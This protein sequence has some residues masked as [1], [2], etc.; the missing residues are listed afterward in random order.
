MILVI[1]ATG[2]IG[3]DVVK[4]LNANGEQVRAMVRDLEKAKAAQEPGVE[5]VTGELEKPETVMAALQSS[6]KAFL[7]SPESEQMPELHG[8][9]AAAAKDAGVRHLVRL[10]IL[11]ANPDAPIPLA[12]WH[13][14]ADRAVMD[15]GVPYTVLRPSYFMQNS[16]GG[17]ATVASDGAI[18]SAMGD[19]KAGQIDTRDIA[20]VAVAVLTSEGHGGQSY[21]LTGPEALSMTEVA[22]RLSSALGKTIEYVNL[23]PDKLTARMVA[24]GVPDWRAEVWVKLAGMIGLGIASMVTPAVKEVLGR[25]PAS[26]DQFAKDFAAEFEKGGVALARKV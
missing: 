20:D 16:L 24:T 14:E 15:S 8:K 1:G 13:G 11:P 19:G 23:T 18:Y 12:K 5:Y 22:A 2:K 4:G 3:K 10:S 6:E 26:I 21:I 7:L 17:G 25:E 9:F